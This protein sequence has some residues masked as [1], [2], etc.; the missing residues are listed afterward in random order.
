MYV[1]RS[2]LYC[3]CVTSAE[4]RFIPSGIFEFEFHFIFG[5]NNNNNNKQ[6]QSQVSFG[7]TVKP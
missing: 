1:D 4:C 6:I 3:G 2:R 5:N 7:E